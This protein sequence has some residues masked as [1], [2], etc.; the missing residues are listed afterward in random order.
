MSQNTNLNEL[1]EE[2]QEEGMLSKQSS[3]ILAVHDIGAQ[4]QAGLGVSVDDVEATEVVLVTMMPDDSGSI[5]FA[6]N[7]Q[8]VRDGHNMVLNALSDSKQKDS[9][10]IHTRYLNGDVLYPYCSLDQAVQMD[11][12][13]YDPYK[14]TPLY[15]QTVVLLG[16]VLAKTK[17]FSDN[18]V[19]VRSVTLILTDGHDEGSHKST[20]SDVAQLARDM[21]A[22]ENHIIAAIGVDDGSINFRSVFKEMGLHDQ[23][24]LT[25]GN[26][27]SE[28]RKA[29]QMFSQ[30][31]VQASQSAA[32]F[33][34]T[35]M[36]GFGG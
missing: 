13:N 9:I 11:K 34:K 27:E 15:D 3:N 10:L 22:S 20:T 19:P 36:G 6:G 1:F 35:A 5:R 21:L 8:A 14:G 4:I 2:A 33:S 23:W 26:N 18:G 28:V 29:F 31:A 32:N 16:T 25:P 30:S 24:I 17:E 12:S 7:A